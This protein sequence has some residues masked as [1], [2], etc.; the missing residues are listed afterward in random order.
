MGTNAEFYQHHLDRV[1]RSFAFCIRQLRDPLREWVGLSYLLCRI[2]DTIEDAPWGNGGRQAQAFERFDQ[3]LLAVTGI[4]AFECWGDLFPEEVS[5]GEKVLIA[6]AARLMRDFHALPT[7]VREIIREMV[8]TMSKG[9]QHFCRQRGGREL[10][11]LSLDEV[12]TYCFFVAGVV[13]ELL[14]KLLAHVEDRFRLSQAMLLNAY[15]FGLFL[16]KVNLLKDQ[17]IDEK[18]GRHLIPSRVVVE[19]S[20]HMNAVAALELILEVPGEQLE[21][22]RF[23]AW[24]FFLGLE[25]LM[26]VR[27]SPEVG[28]VVK[29]ARSRT[30]EILRVVESRLTHSEGLR[31][32]FQSYANQLGWFSATM[33]DA[34]DLCGTP[35]GRPL[36]D[37]LLKTYRGSLD[38]AALCT[39]GMG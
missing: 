22:R 11:L 37:W 38:A 16:Q 35:V 25:S 6:D 26:V 9:M 2:V 34:A 13:G 24:S 33:G 30:Q 27:S 10:R 1:S 15:N 32:L 18:L 31:E 28:E 12:N 36:P 23:C 39:L 29:V 8:L 21:F 3:A 7:P 4:Q 19:E 20:A 14:V 5:S 17:V